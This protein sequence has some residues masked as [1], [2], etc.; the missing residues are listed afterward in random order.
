M[1]EIQFVVSVIKAPSV[2]GHREK[3]A[4]KVGLKEVGSVYRIDP[5]NSYYSADTD[6]HGRWVWE[7]DEGCSLDFQTSLPTR[8]KAVYAMLAYSDHGDDQ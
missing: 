8:L 7:S 5:R 2:A 1:S 4:V 3:F 6:H